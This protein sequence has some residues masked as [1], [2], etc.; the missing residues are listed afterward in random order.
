MQTPTIP[1]DRFEAYW[2][3]DSA[4]LPKGGPRPAP[5]TQSDFL[6]LN[7]KI[8]ECI[9]STT[10]RRT[11]R[12]FEKGLNGMKGRLFNIDD[13]GGRFNPVR[14]AAMT[15][16]IQGAI[17]FGT[18]EE[19]FLSPLRSVSISCT[20]PY[21]S[22]SVF[23]LFFFSLFFVLSLSPFFSPSFPPL[24]FGS[25][26]YDISTQISMPANTF[27]TNFCKKVIAI[28]RYLREPEVLGDVQNTRRRLDAQARW[29]SQ[30][31]N[32]LRNLLSI[33]QEFDTD[34]WEA[35]ATW[36]HD[37]VTGIIHRARTAY[38]TAIANGQSPTNA[39]RVFNELRLIEADL[40][41][42]LTLPP[43]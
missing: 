33:F 32:D 25:G 41:Y 11:F 27:P 34:Y 29:A 43:Y 12:M 36:A 42:I 23:S 16:Y 31:V 37:W 20:Y 14:D 15:Q 40:Q 17:V 22:V 5:N 7:D 3:Y 39:Q 2:N 4:N 1:F 18:G 24:F 35:A 21:F 26:F 8:F 30:Q 13:S 38:Q 6:N 28:W 19:N 10:N 9:G